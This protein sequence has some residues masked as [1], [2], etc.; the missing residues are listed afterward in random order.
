MSS[1][2]QQDKTRLALKPQNLPQLLRDSRFWKIALQAIAV[3]L[4]V[5]TVIIL[6][7]NLIYNRQLLGR[8]LGFEFLDS[9][10]SFDIGERLINYERSNSFGRAMVVG[11]LNSL[12]IMVFGIILATIF[13]LLVGIARLSDNWLLRNLA[14]VYVEIVRNTPL[15][16]QLLF[17]YS[18]VFLQLP[19]PETSIALP[20]SIYLTKKAIALPW[21]TSNTAT[22][23]WLILLSIGI[24][25][26]ALVWRWRGHLRVEQGKPGRIILW[27]S[28]MI[29]TALIIALIVTQSAPFLWNLP[30]VTTDAQLEGGL[31]LS[32]EFCALLTGLVVYTV[33][34]IAEIVRAG[35][36]AVPKGQWEAARALGLK[37]GTIMQLVIL[38][39]ALRVI[40][41]SLTSQYLNLAKNSSLAI[42]IGFPD[43]YSIANTTLNQ[44]NKEVEVILIIGAIYL[45]ISLIISISMNLFNRQVQIK[46]R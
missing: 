23:I 2:P 21:L 42:A 8:P 36:Q 22:G 26:A 31:Q 1:S 9:Q 28:G 40:I 45:I 4:V 19:L 17:W 11:L 7:D 34:F 24:I 6:T 38:P 33:S 46:E 13:G 15:L 35:I 29:I 25:I 14:L 20:G 44:T 39:Q 10:A 12:R 43:F 5:A 41:P 27:T 16:L 32:P 37:S 30:R 3:L 18:A